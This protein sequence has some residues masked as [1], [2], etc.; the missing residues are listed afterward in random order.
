MMT[1]LGGCGGG[2]E[3]DVMFSISLFTADWWYK[4][5]LK[6]QRSGRLWLAHR[7]RPAAYADAYDA[8]D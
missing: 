6:A 3:A 5:D 8:G 2:S 7:D 1:T 4:P